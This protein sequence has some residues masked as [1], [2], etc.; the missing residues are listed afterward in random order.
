[1]I[2]LF[3]LLILVL[4]PVLYYLINEFYGIKKVVNKELGTDEDVY[5]GDACI[6]LDSDLYNDR[7]YTDENQ[8]IT[9]DLIERNE[10]GLGKGIKLNA[11]KHFKVKCDECKKYIYKD[12]KGQCSPYAYDGRYTASNSLGVC[13]AIGYAKPCEQ[14]TKI[15]Q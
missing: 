9:A 3:V 6:F 11:G 15:L 2:I 4:I 1:M 7:L 13:T 10:K 8:P 14:V 12:E 5:G